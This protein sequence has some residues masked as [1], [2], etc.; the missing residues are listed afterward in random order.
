MKL[1]TRVANSSGTSSCSRVSI[2]KNIFYR[3]DKYT[4][5][6]KSKLVNGK[7]VF[8]LDLYCMSGVSDNHHLELA[9]HLTDSES[10]VTASEK[11]IR[12]VIQISINLVLQ[13]KRKRKRTERMLPEWVI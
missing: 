3:V 10:S 5:T 11:S 2:V 4:R 13:K 12:I 6:G 7:H 9:L 8:V 1:R